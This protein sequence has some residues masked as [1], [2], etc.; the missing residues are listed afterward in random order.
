MIQDVTKQVPLSLSPQN[1]VWDLKSL[2][3]ICGDFQKTIQDCRR[4]L[5][6]QSRFGRGRGG[7]IYNIQ[8]NLSVEPEITRLKDRVAFHNIKVRLGYV[9]VFLAIRQLT[10]LDFYYSQ[11]IGTVGSLCSWTNPYWVPC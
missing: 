8:W 5:E 6:D 1:H 11:T 10:S 9:C 4:L 7:F 3:Q 2:L